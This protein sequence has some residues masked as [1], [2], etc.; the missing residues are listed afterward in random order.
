MPKHARQRIGAAL[1]L[2]VFA[3]GACT[4]SETSAG[5]AAADSAEPAGGA[6]T[7]W[8][9]STELFMEHPALIV[10]APDKFAVHLTDLTDFAPLR[11]GR[12]T[13]TFRPRG[14]GDPVTVIQ[15]TPRAPGIYGPAPTFTRPGTYDLTILVDSPQARDGIVVPGLVVYA[16]A[17][18]A[19]RDEGGAESGVSFLKEQQWK[20]PGFATAFATDGEV[21]ATF[22][23]SGVL[24][25]QAGR[26]AQV[27][28]PVAGLID[29]SGVADSPLPG[30]RVVRGQVLAVLAPSLGEGGGAAVAEARARLREAEDEHDRAQRLYAVEAVP[31]RRVHEAEIRLTAAREALAGYGADAGGRVSVRSPIAGVVAERRVAPGSRVEAG[32]SLFTIVDASVVWLRVNV[33][34][35]QAPSVSR[36]SNVEFQMEGSPRRYVSRRVVSVGSIV[37]SLSRTIP[38]L[39]EVA[40]LDGSLKIGANASVAVRTGAR[41]RGI[42][43]PASAVLDEDGRAIAYVQP[44]GETFEKR[45]LTIVGREGGRVLVSAGIAAGERVVTGA[46]YQVR[47]AS[48]STSVPAQGHEH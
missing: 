14:G 44:E 8:T 42:V 26:L 34:A 15:E 24:E 36:T 4:R 29:V 45:E 43:L 40:N 39:F 28:A 25:A 30:Q 10:G 48:L 35:A 27:S 33:P 41:Q 1:T 37:D 7:R 13:L 5:S 22:E 18:D 19:P 20:T 11:T 47:L 12:I 38:V 31:Q 21:A 2:A 3:L 23:A 32:A 9:D 46:A 6:I 16:T 17:A